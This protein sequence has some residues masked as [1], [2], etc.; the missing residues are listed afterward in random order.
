MANVRHTAS[1]M[2]VHHV[3]STQNLQ[4]SA[5]VG[6]KYM[7]GNCMSCRSDASIR[8]RRLAC[9]GWYPWRWGTRNNFIEWH[10]KCWC[11][12]LLC[13]V[14]SF[15]VNVVW[16]G[17][18]PSG[19]L[20]EVIFCIPSLNFSLH[21]I[22]SSERVLINYIASSDAYIAASRVDCHLLT[23]VHSVV[24]PAFYT[25]APDCRKTL[26]AKILWNVSCFLWN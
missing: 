14:L 7:L 20:L 13:F 24:I 2:D 5:E 21:R 12:I 10:H 8:W 6:R 22:W 18:C 23:A 17:T 9:A 15:L 19:R 26:P 11:V 25:G 3:A 1:E 16:I 4:P